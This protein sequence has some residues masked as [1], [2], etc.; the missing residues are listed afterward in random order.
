MADVSNHTFY[1]N[2]EHHYFELVQKDESNSTIVAKASAVAWKAGAS[3]IR[4]FEATSGQRFKN[5]IRVC[6]SVQ[7]D[8]H[9]VYGIKLIMLDVDP[10]YTIG[11]LELQRLATIDRL[12]KE[13]TSHVQKEW[14]RFKTKNNS[15]SHK[16]VI[17]SIAVLSSSASAGYQDFMHT[18]TQNT[19]DYKFRVNSYFTTIQGEANAE[20][21]CSKIGEICSSAIPF[22]AVVIIRGGGADTDFL[23]FDQFVLCDAVAKLPIPVITGIGHL[24]NETI[25]DL[26]A[27]T[28]T[29]TPTKAAEFIIAHNQSFEQSLLVHQQRIIIKSQQIIKKHAQLILSQNALMAR[30]GRALISV[31]KEVQERLK[32]RMMRQS[33]KLLNQ[34]STRLTELANKSLYKPQ[35]LISSHKNE[36]KNI[37]STV[38]LFSAK[39]LINQNNNIGYYES[40]CRMMSPINILKKGFALLYQSYK[41]ITE[42]C[43]LTEGESIKV[44]LIDCELEA[45]IEQK[46]EIHGDSFNL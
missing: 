38:K 23:I 2:K 22:D 40:M 28:A 7:I 20:A 8:Y 44:R 5:G 26:M 33:K 46:Q 24:K 14:Q 10:S 18:L 43:S 29:K 31:K 39:L 4:A 15:L 27:H 9:P 35:L 30:K 25:V 17:Q 19:F 16:R 21:A 12:L 42:G 3:K 34:Q 37:A 36:L 11:Q 45:T 41:I 6:V 32:E 1:P 13:C